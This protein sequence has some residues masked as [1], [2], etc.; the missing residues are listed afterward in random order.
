MPEPTTGALS[1][2]GAALL[3]MILPLKARISGLSKSS[4]HN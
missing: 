1:F 2:I 4:T 3:C